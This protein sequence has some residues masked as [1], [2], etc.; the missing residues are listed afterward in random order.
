MN[1]EVRAEIMKGSDA[2]T[3]RKVGVATGMTTLMGDA[4]NKVMQ[5]ITTVEEVL[6]VIQ[7]NT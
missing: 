2:S 7:E 3:V 4:A 5:W 1:D 6:R